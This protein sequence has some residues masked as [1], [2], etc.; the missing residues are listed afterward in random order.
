MNKQT[1]V[2]RLKEETCIIRFLKADGSEREMLATLNPNAVP[3][4]GTANGAKSSNSNT[5]TQAV[6][7]TVIGAWR[8]FRWENVT[9]FQGQDFAPGG[10][11]E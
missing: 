4:F 9:H 5:N 7:D 8:S 1:I 2:S 3:Y 6:W 11:T 10:V